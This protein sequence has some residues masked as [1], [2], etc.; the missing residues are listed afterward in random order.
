M[1]MSYGTLTGPKSTA[2]SI[3]YWINYEL[4]DVEGVV[5]DAQAYIYGGLRTREMKSVT[6]VTITGG[7]SSAPLP[8]GFLEPLYFQLPNGDR[9]LPA[10]EADLLASRI[11]DENGDLPESDPTHFAIWDE[12]FQ[13][14]TVVAA[15]TTA[16]L[17][18]YRRPP[19]L[20][21]QTQT[22]FLTSRYPNLVRAACL[23]FAA[24]GLQDDQEYGRWKQ[25]ADELIARANIEADLVARGRDY[26]ASVR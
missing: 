7:A 1:D 24:D 14:D 9:I 13:F 3:R 5:M 21:R 19:Y 8:T 18:F 10:D 17:L 26:S 4:I 20:G 12:A 15:D 22:N 6:P 2:G 16:S 23:M 11:P 25:R